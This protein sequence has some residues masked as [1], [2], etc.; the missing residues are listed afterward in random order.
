V[1]PHEPG[2]F[3]VLF[4]RN[5]AN[6]EFVP[7]RHDAVFDA[8][9]RTV[10]G[11]REWTDPERAQPLGSVLAGGTLRNHYRSQRGA[12]GQLRLP[13]LVSVGDAVCTTTPNFGRGSALS[14]LQVQELLRLIDEG[15]DAIASARR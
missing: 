11:L 13:G 5:A 15:S 2:I 7:L 6:R 12:D 3:S 10:P 1:F 8:V 14:M 4:V 9:A